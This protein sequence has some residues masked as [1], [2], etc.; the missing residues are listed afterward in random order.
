M[1]DEETQPASSTASRPYA[2]AD[3]HGTLPRQVL[4]D[5]ETADYIAMSKSWLRQSRMT[6]NPDA[7]PFVKIGRAVRYLRK[8]LDAWLEQ[9]RRPN[10]SQK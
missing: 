3:S 5:Q 6:G 4:T 10:T 2:N 1:R 8:D 7:P 9:R